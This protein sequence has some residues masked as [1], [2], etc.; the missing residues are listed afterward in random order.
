MGTSRTSSTRSPLC[1]HA[2]LVRSL[3]QRPKKACWVEATPQSDDT[4]HAQS[5]ITCDITK[6]LMR[7]FFEFFRSIC[8]KCRSSCTLQRCF[9]QQGHTAVVF[10]CSVKITV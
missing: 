10:S 4:V 2:G 6:V 3:N 7:F 8:S 1:L 5:S 9:Q